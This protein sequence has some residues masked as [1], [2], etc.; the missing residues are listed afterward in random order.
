MNPNPLSLNKAFALYLL[1]FE[2]NGGGQ[3]TVTPGLVHR[4]NPLDLKTMYDMEND[5]GK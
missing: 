5:M 2:E 3:Q 4:A 1:H